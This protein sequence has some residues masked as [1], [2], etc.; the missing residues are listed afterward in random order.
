MGQGIVAPPS[1]NID[2]VTLDAVD[3]FTYLGCKQRH[4]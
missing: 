1:I 4:G 3:S 2:N